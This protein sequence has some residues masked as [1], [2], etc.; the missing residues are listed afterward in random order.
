MES[1]GF[2][3]ALSDLED[4]EAEVEAETVCT[5]SLL[6]PVGSGARD[7]LNNEELEVS[8]FGAKN[9]VSITF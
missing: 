1:C 3:V 2:E 8:E 7:H 6:N 5:D 4:S 9:S